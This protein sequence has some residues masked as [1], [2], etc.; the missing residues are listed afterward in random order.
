MRTLTSRARRAFTLIEVLIV[1]AVMALLV[2]LLLPALGE[3]RRAARLTVCHSNMHQLGAATQTYTADFQD[4]IWGLSWTPGNAPTKYADLKDPTSDI[5]AVAF[6]AIDIIR[7]RADREDFK[8]THWMA[9][10]LHSHLALLDYLA[11]RLPEKT[12]VCPEHRELVRWQSDPRAFDKGALNPQPSPS[13]H[14]KRIPFRS[15]YEASVNL[16][17]V[18]EVGERVTQIAFGSNCYNTPTGLRLRLQRLSSVQYP[19]NKAHLFDYTQRHFGRLYPYFGLERCRQPILAFDGSVIVRQNASANRGW[20]PNDPANPEPTII[21]HQ[22]ASWEPP[23]IDPSGVDVGFGHYRWTRGGIQ[24]I[25]FGGGE[26]NTGQ[27]RP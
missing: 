24:G 13:N 25:D 27:L 18:S 7:R 15:S 20:Q 4:R 23:T 3:Q 5:Q 26:I 6:Q 11:A 22:A 14:N 19:S 16:F 10:P 2:A 12:V 1:I 8:A 17:D 9:T 21:E